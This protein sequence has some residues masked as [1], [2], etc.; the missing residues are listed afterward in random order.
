[1]QIVSPPLLVPMNPNRT[2][3]HHKNLFLPQTTS[4]YDFETPS[5]NDISPIKLHDKSSFKTIIK[6]QQTDIPNDRLRHPSQNQS[7]LPP[8][9][10]YR[11]TKTHYNLRHQPKMDYRLFIP[12]SKL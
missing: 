11:T 3:I 5:S 4:K 2:K 1:M 7:I 10:K 8:P 6:P 12:P 9:P